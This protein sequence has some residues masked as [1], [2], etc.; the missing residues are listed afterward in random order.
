MANIGDRVLFGLASSV[1]RPA[2][3]VAPAANDEWS[4]NVDVSPGDDEHLEPVEQVAFQ[5][6]Q[7]VGDYSYQRPVCV[8]A[9]VAAEAQSATVG[10]FWYPLHRFRDLTSRGIL[11]RVLPNQARVHR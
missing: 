8:V 1:N 4:I 11:P 3:L 5:P 10:S 9:R 6:I 7:T 2:V